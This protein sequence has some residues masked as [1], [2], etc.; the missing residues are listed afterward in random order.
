MVGKIEYIKIFEEIMIEQMGKM[1]N[2][3]YLDERH[4]K[5]LCIIFT[6]ILSLF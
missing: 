1:F 6:I 5:S 2:L 3:G 4:T